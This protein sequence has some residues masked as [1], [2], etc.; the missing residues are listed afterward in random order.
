MFMYFL[1]LLRR[2]SPNLK[3]SECPIKP[4]V[5]PVNNTHQLHNDIILYPVQPFI[6]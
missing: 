1:D 3:S 2:L 6:F 4:K 5:I